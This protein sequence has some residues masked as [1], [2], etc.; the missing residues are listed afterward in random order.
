M[1]AGRQDIGYKDNSEGAWGSTEIAIRC[2]SGDNAQWQRKNRKGALIR[3][4]SCCCVLPLLYRMDA[5]AVA[6]TP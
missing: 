6:L 1:S 3:L 4:N 5:S 2:R